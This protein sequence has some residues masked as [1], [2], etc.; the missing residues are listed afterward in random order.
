MSPSWS[1]IIRWC[2]HFILLFEGRPSNV[3]VNILTT[4]FVL[5]AQKCH[6][7][8]Q[9]QA[10]KRKREHAYDS[11][12]FVR[13]KMR[14]C[15][16]KANPR[17][18]KRTPLRWFLIRWHENARLLIE[19]KS[20]NAKGNTLTMVLYSLM[21]KYETVLQNQ[22]SMHKGV[23]YSK[24]PRAT[25]IVFSRPERADRR[26]PAEKLRKTTKYNRRGVCR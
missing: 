4:V 26:R 19:S 5:F 17:A 18:Q 2:R 12:K 3:K 9:K 6:T 23:L 16:S 11:S 1:I 7:A 25:I 24:R 21:Q 15:C 8:F 20:L 10:L 22:T 14:Y 13:T